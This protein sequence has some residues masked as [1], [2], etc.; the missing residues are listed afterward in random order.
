MG[1]A[2]SRVVSLGGGAALVNI[3]ANFL[4][5][6][7]C[8]S[9]KVVSGLVGFGLR[10]AWVRSTAVCVP[11]YFEDSLGKVSVAGKNAVVLENF[12]FPSWGC[13]TLCSGN[14]A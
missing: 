1:Y 6:A 14:V 11:T 4:M 9:P 8:L 5:D 3:S 2:P 10:R 13:R 7:I 12:I